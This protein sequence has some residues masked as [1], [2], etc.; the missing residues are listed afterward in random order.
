[1]RSPDFSC[2]MVAKGR[3]RIELFDEIGPSWYG[4]IDEKTVANALKEVGEVTD[5]DVLVNSLGGD[6]YDGTAIHNLLKAHPAKVHMKV[7]GIAASAATL[8]LMAGDTITIPKNAQIMIHAP[9]TFAFGDESDVTAA[10]ARLQSGKESA[11]Q[12]YMG[13]NKKQSREQ[14]AAYMA[15]GVETWFTGS[16]A[17][18]AGFA[19]QTEAEVQLPTVEPKAKAQMK[20]RNAPEHLTALLALSMQAKEIPTMTTQET[21]TTATGAAAPVVPATPAPIPALTQADVT[22]AQKEAVKAERERSANITALCNM[23]GKPELAVKLVGDEN[24]TVAS[25]QAKLFQHLCQERK[26]IEGGGAG[27]AGTG[28]L[29]QTTDPDASLKAEYAANKAYFEAKGTTEAEFIE[30]SKTTMNGGKIPFKS[31]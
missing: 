31:K 3:A 25:V 27:T 2:K 30:S 8:V 14:I 15:S 5:I 9:M 4:M 16:E 21:T 28:G 26:P 19:D 6:V 18:E 22:A 29:E 11:L 20:F 12:T 7:M 23:A 10:L 13:R 1:M 24:E 17:V